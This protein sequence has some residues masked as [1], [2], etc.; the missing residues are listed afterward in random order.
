M[1]VYSIKRWE[2]HGIYVAVIE[3]L[4]T[5]ITHTPYRSEWSKLIRDGFNGRFIEF[6]VVGDY[7]DVPIAEAEN[8]LRDAKNESLMEVL[9]SVQG[10]AKDNGLCRDMHSGNAML[11]EDGTIVIT[12][13]FSSNSAK[14][15]E[16]LKA[17]GV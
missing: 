6:D 16:T 17:M 3:R 1:K 13:P 2:K 15:L 4:K 11:R 12:D 10:F 14:A 5:E 9:L 8:F 7:M